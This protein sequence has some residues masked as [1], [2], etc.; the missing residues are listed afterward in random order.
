MTAQIIKDSLPTTPVDVWFEHT[1][2]AVRNFL[3]SAVV[4][5]NQPY[6]P[7][8]SSY[9]A[10]KVDFS[11]TVD[12]GFGEELEELVAPTTSEE[13]ALSD[14]ALAHILDVRKVSDA[15]A[16]NGMTCAFV[17]P[18]DSDPD[19]I[20][21]E[22]RVLGAAKISDI[23]VI[24][25]Y[26]R[27]NVPVLTLELLEKIAL[28]D[29]KESG[30]MRLICVYTGQPLDEQIFTDVKHAIH[31]GGIPLADIPNSP[32][33][34]KNSSCVVVLL[35]KTE[36]PPSELSNALIERFAL[37]ADG[38]LPSFALSAV[39][40]I[41]KNIHHMVTRFGSNLDSAFVANRLITNPPEDVAELVRELLV[42][43]CDNALGIE[44]IADQY[45]AE[46]AIEAW[47]IKNGSSFLEQ[48]YGKKQS[49]D[50]ALRSLLL[51]NG[52]DNIGAKNGTEKSIE[53]PVK[54][55]NKVSI[56]LAG[57]ENKSKES[58]AAFSKLV[59]FKREAFGDTKLIG[60]DGWRPSLT[61]GTLLRMQEGEAK[62]YFVCLTPAC[63]TLRLS[64]ETPFVFLEAAIDDNCYS[65]VLRE[66][67]GED[68][69]LYFRGKHPTLMTYKFLPDAK[70]QRIRGE[71]HHTEHS[72]PTFT[73]STSSGACRFT[74]LGEIRYARAASEMAK[75]AGNWMRIGISDSE[76]LRLTEAGKFK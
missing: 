9:I 26:L 48:P 72:R 2:S 3:K 24:D 67:D 29:V 16:G 6:V 65:I 25:W 8:P 4:I 62:R 68:R 51:K 44:S 36:V 18:E 10:Q 27:D 54:H 56:S 61:T 64:E 23:V 70:S 58:E 12:S 63:D 55:R 59:V 47:L 73:F 46:A 31:R 14:D 34:A 66:E 40:A 20:S 76:Y 22:K 74:W 38:L 41:R 50:N 39:G 19:V 28:D 15:F 49:V 71:P 69:G 57:D 11:P 17:L 37:F 33:C 42:A 53:F 35:N 1:I 7:Q 5:D 32:Y 45:L 43:E 21:I 13:A 75:L 52:I 30:R 60:G